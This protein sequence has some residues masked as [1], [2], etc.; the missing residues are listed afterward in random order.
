MRVHIAGTLGAAALR[1]H[2]AQL[3]RRFATWPA[4]P[5]G[6]A[7]QYALRHAL[8]HRAVGGDWAG[9][10]RLAADMGFLEA[11][12]RELGAHEAEA[13]AARAAE[14][15]RA[16]GEAII[17]RRFADLARA[18]ARESHWLRSAPEAT[19]ALLWNRLRRTGWSADEI[20]AQLRVPADSFLR[21]RAR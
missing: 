17:G 14:R 10:W 7:R 5:E 9:A 3:A 12:C 13:D 21:V 4:P 19:A 2:H 6:P 1:A 15:C 11:K 16:S 18:L 20:D 8:I